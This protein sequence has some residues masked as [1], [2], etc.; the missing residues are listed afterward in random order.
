MKDSV[1]KFAALA[2]LVI[3]FVA[4]VI[5]DRWIDDSD[6]VSVDTNSSQ[7]T[8]PSRISTEAD[9]LDTDSETERS[10]VRVER[11][12]NISVQQRKYNRA[13]AERRSEW[14]SN[15]TT[16]EQDDG[17]EPPDERQ[18]KDIWRSYVI[19]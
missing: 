7:L 16:E 13:L 9:T 5:T 17:G 12:D 14:R 8:Q 10:A 4:V 1:T 11:T 3:V 19:E 2:V 18:D 15:R 6:G